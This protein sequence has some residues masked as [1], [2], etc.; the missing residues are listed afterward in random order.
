VKRTVS[1]L[2][3]AAFLAVLLA[4][5]P[6]VAAAPDQ[7]LP[8][9]PVHCASPPCG[10]IYPSLRVDAAVEDPYHTSKLSAFPTTIPITITYSWDMEQEGTGLTDPTTDMQITIVLTRVPAWM[11]AR[12]D[13]HVCTFTLFPLNPEGAADDSMT[14]YDVCTVTLTTALRP[15]HF[16]ANEAQL[17]ESGH[18][19][20]LF[21]A[22]EESGTFMKSYGLEDIR[23]RWDSPPVR[24][25]GTV[26]TAEPETTESP[27][28]L[29]LLLVVGLAGLA[30]RF[31][32]R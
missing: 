1:A 21:A 27:S 13:T 25:D 19:L 20:M 26:P 4:A 22:S 30:A 16:P 32:R 18:R 28:M 14:H 3:F 9:L 7:A 23:F 31:R 6:P 29:P 2:P 8:D 15:E 5:V 17:R 24:P 10:Y 12:L 11:S